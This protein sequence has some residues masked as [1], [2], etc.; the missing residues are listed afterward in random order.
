MNKI[1][2]V[3]WNHATQ[4]WVATSEL[5]R[6]KGKSKTKS[7]ALAVVAAGMG[8]C[9]AESAFAATAIGVVGNSLV[10]NTGGGWQYANTSNIPATPI[11]SAIGIN[12][13]AMGINVTA[14]G[15]NAIAF[16]NNASAIGID[17]TAI[18]INASAT[19]GSSAKST[20]IGANTNVTAPQGTAIG[21]NASV[22]AGNGIAIGTNA[23]AIR[24]EAGSER[25]VTVIG[26]D[27]LIRN[28]ESAGQ[29]R[30]ATAIGSNALAGLLTDAGAANGTAVSTSNGDYKTSSGDLTA[31]RLMYRA[32]ITDATGVTVRKLESNEA[33][34]IGFDSRAIGDQ[35]IAIGA[36]VVSG[37]SSV[38][39]GSNDM[40]AVISD[41]TRNT[42]KD[43]VGTDLAEN[44]LPMPGTTTRWYETTYAKD[45]SVA[46]GAKA[47]SNALFGT[48]LGTSAFVQ[49]GAELGTAIGT[50]A[51][52]G[53]QS[54]PSGDAMTSTANFTTKGGVA[55]AAGAVAERDFT[56]AVGT[57]ANALNT[58]A[59][60]LGY[61]ALAN[62]TNA[63]AVGANAQAT[64]T[65]AL[66][67][68]ANAKS[69]ASDGVAI[70]TN[71]TV[72][73]T[74]NS[75]VAF[76]TDTSV[77][78]KKTVA[79]GSNI[80]NVSTDGSVV[81]GDA[82]TGVLTNTDG[83][84]KVD[85]QTDLP[86]ASHGVGTVANAT[87]TGGNG[88]KITYSGF[89]G[90]PKDAGK[91]VSIGAV[92]AERQLKNVAAGNID[93]NS[94]DGINGSQ[95]YALAITL[96]DQVFQSTYFHTN[97]VTNKDTGNAITN[98]GNVTDSAGAMGDYSVTA[99][100]NT[101][102][103][104]GAG[105]AIGYQAATT[106]DSVAIGKDAK[107]YGIT[108]GSNAVGISPT[109]YGSVAIGN[110]S[111]AAD[112]AVA[113]GT[114]AKVDSQSAFAAEG[115]IAIG[116][117]ALVDAT[118]GSASA[119]IAIGRK[120]FAEA[121][122]PKVNGNAV[123]IT[124]PNGT[125]ISDGVATSVGDH[126]RAAQGGSAFGQGS[127]ARAYAT[128]VGLA[129]YAEGVM[130]TAVGYK[131]HS[132]GRESTAIGNDITANGFA[133]VA[134]GN[135]TIAHENSTI[136]IGNN[137]TAGTAATD[138][139]MT[140]AIA[141]GYTSNAS[142]KRGVALGAYAGAS[143]NHAAALG[144]YA[145]ALANSS[146]ASG[147]LATVT[148]ESSIAIGRE[149]VVSGANST[150]LGQ[151]NNV[152]GVES[153]AIGKSSQ[154]TGN[155]SIAVGV[156]H[157]IAANNS[158]TFGDPN[159]ILAGADRSYAVGN[160]NT[161]TTADT[162]V[163]G[164]NV[165]RLADGSNNTVGTVE[166]SVY[167]GNGTEATEGV[168]SVGADGKGTLFTLNTDQVVG[169][170]A[171]TAGDTGTVS[172]ATVGGVTYGTFAGATANGVVSVGAAGAER[173]IQNVAAGEISSTS[174]DAINGS[175]LYAVYDKAAKPVTFTAN[176][177]LDTANTSAN[178]RANNGL[179]RQLGD[180]LSV[181]GAETAIALTRNTDNAV[182]GNYSAKNIQTIVDDQGVQIQMAENPE[183]ESMN[184]T[185]GTNSTVITPTT[186]TV[187][188]K[189]GNA[190]KP[191]TITSG[192]NGGIIS[193]LTTTLPDVVT[194]NTTD[195]DG[196]PVNY[197]T[198]IVRPTIPASILTNAATLGD[199][200]N[201][202]WNLQEN[203][204]A[205]DFVKPYDTVNFANGTG[206]TVNIT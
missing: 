121:N 161:V 117:D 21:A 106:G 13:I 40:N 30:G 22:I 90:Q 174:T 79:L 110:S 82:S 42:Y 67:Y 57:G 183:F 17:N 196:N 134:I 85:P 18:G 39:I 164:S 70:G 35:S 122:A 114:N 34:A 50:G 26:N 206:T 37:H 159:Y 54:I 96:G 141:I 205:R 163:F 142:G 98:L 86:G 170:A 150:T 128:A 145:K 173:R 131:V 28:V 124:I 132:Q 36:Q 139:D 147:V 156:G 87:V 105:A 180:T 20:A 75:S 126:A 15:A 133:S 104:V 72:T 49:A 185:D 51:R 46:I 188:D 53:A 138:D 136:A 76:G 184:I 166:N 10:V 151:L 172:N 155:Q 4:S 125:G 108:S 5:S 71:S 61:K 19:G 23:T 186:I 109:A 135:A 43:I 193:N 52:V 14:N 198:N 31:A 8:L 77:S 97:N 148:G 187:G 94:T 101:T 113:I 56:T 32:G 158:G 175:Q 160:N 129:A 62:G 171:T 66:A 152:S 78:G 81:L 63:T 92:G 169:T 45:G 202:G 107:A 59:T 201:A 204:G 44:N 25:A 103:K 116:K 143:H 130:S 16:G 1:F 154:V 144:P 127:D 119:S 3:I 41:T 65:D 199:V 68:G 194:M 192:D 112:G 60:A 95:L 27:A 73:A 6:A 7:V 12:A 100:V 84:I 48:A 88:A 24:N 120:A 29:N 123:T 157:V 146:I 33:T 111:V 197:T 153:I 99:G 203:G 182:T 83:T 91:Y 74:G 178:Y 179:E 89:S 162:F 181:K 80:K 38:A 168:G 190:D 55:I 189:A 137:A 118:S 102:A 47:H 200:L 149:S 140:E 167:L 191:V 64:A 93:A 58:R 195:G 176:T 2:K 115:A 9:A 177:N 69:F 165:N 11:A